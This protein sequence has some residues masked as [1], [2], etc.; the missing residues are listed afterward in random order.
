MTDLDATGGR[1]SNGDDYTQL[2]KGNL[3]VT[4]TYFIWTTNMRGDRLDA[5]LVKV[6]YQWLVRNRAYV[7]SGDHVQTFTG[8]KHAAR[9]NNCE[10]PVT[11]VS[12]ETAARA[13]EIPAGH[14]PAVQPTSR[15]S[16]SFPGRLAVRRAAGFRPVL[17]F[18][19][20]G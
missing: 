9:A 13:P 19:R 7:V 2:P 1:D 10:R 12:R 3:D 6:P 5:F 11:S 4:G 18:P 8:W 15:D 16:C 20:S 17:L 14:G